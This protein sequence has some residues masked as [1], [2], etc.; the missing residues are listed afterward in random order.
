MIQAQLRA[1]DVNVRMIFLGHVR[2]ARATLHAVVTAV[3]AVTAYINLH[4]LSSTVS[5]SQVIIPFLHIFFQVIYV[6]F[7]KLNLNSSF[8]PQRSISALVWSWSRFVIYFDIWLF[9]IHLSNHALFL[10][11]EVNHNTDTLNTKR[12]NSSHNWNLHCN[13]KLHS[14]HA[15]QRILQ[16][17]WQRSL[18][19]CFCRC[20]TFLML[21]L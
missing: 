17:P 13:W 9:H 16:W 14:K 6:K 10:N 3:Q 19:K 15:V 2:C 20:K 21:L 12:D 5:Q 11:S 1:C 8:V 4:F 18:Q 7:L